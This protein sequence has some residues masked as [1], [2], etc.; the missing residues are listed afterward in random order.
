MN[1]FIK[2]GVVVLALGSM[3]LAQTAATSGTQKKKSTAPKKMVTKA[4]AATEQDIQQLKDMLQQQQQQ[5]QQLQQ[6]MAQR[7]QQLADAQAAAREAQSKTTLLETTANEQKATTDKLANDLS[8]VKLVQTNAATTLQETQKDIAEKINNPSSLRY[9]GITITPGG[10][11]EA[12]GVWRQRSEQTD[13]LSTFNGIP[14]SGSPAGHLTEFR[15]TARQSRLSLLA[16]GKV[17]NTKLTGYWEMDF[18]GAAPTANENQ[19]NSFT[20]RQRQLFG[21]AAMDNGW[22]FTAGQTWSLITLNK[23]GIETRGEWLPAT[24]DAQYVPGYDFA[25][26]MTA[27]VTKSFMNKKAAV[28]FSVENN[29]TLFGGINTPGNVITTL[30]GGG[31]LGNGNNYTVALAPDF[32]AKVAFDPGWGHYEIKG[33][34][35]FFR[36]RVALATS[37]TTTIG[38]DNNTKVGGGVGFGAILPVVKSKVDVIAQGLFGNGVARYTDSSNVDVVIRPDGTVSPVKSY[39]ALLGVETHP[40]PKFDWYVYAGN[41]YLGRNAGSMLDLTGTLKQFGYGNPTLNI[42]NCYTPIP[43]SSYA[44]SANFKAITQGTTG[45]YYRMY[46]GPF[47]TLQYGVQLSYTHKGFWDGQNG[48]TGVPGGLAG[49]KANETMVLTNFRYF[50]P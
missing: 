6:Q 21:Q 46:K 34:G 3:C 44:C 33:L 17:G 18:L 2:K 7:D 25:R 11:I 29:A 4:P 40:T 32:I 13:V 45:F 19:S 36:D 42:A 28:A 14:F 38:G 12:A 15:G 26:L 9:K 43:E 47:G 50:I 31:S 35:R 1:T 16:E 20:P 27:R 49:P 24:I 30:P 39:S 41:E 10:F 48:A 22:T 8:D 37:G 23:K 5:I